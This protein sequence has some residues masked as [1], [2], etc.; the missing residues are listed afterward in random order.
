MEWLDSAQGSGYHLHG[1]YG[2]L[3]FAFRFPD[4]KDAVVFAL[5]WGDDS[6][7]EKY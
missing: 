1:W 2:T 4:P 5:R 7:V 3:G 6:G